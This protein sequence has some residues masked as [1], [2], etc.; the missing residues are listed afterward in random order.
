M[1]KSWNCVFEFFWP[2]LKMCLITLSDVPTTKVFWE[3]LVVSVHFTF[4]WQLKNLA[5]N[6]LNSLS[7]LH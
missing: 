5:E 4:K 2:I 6:N 7:Q 1:E 3:N